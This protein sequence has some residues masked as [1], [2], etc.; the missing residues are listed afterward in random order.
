MRV[1]DVANA[2]IMKMSDL[3]LFIRSNSFKYN[4]WFVPIKATL[5]VEVGDVDLDFKIQLLNT[6]VNYTNNAT[7]KSEIRVIPQIKIE[8]AEL[9]IDPKKMKFNIGGS[10]VAQVVDVILPMFSRL[11]TS[12]MNS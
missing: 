5:D 3:Y 11:I 12:I 4:L 8:K 1:D 7:G 2:Y 6:T 10:V 9:T